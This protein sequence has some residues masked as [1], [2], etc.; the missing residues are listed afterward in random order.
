MMLKRL[1]KKESALRY[2]FIL[3]LAFLI[4]STISQAQNVTVAQKNLTW[5]SEQ[6]IEKHSGVMLNS[7]SRIEV[8]AGAS[9]DLVIQEQI[10]SFSIE[11]ITG[12]WA[13]EDQDGSLE[14][15]IKY[16]S[17]LPGKMVITR[18]G[19]R[20]EISVNM[21]EANPEGIHFVFFVDRVTD[22]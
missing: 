14:Y 3:L 7:G 22:N 9:V 8:H 19:G 15:T 21:T 12:S 2:K 6:C 13:S 10:T 18:S 20:T 5:Y 17:T 4:C 16:N 11:S 1:L